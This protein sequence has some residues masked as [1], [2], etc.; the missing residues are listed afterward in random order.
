ML[1]GSIIP[2]QHNI[3]IGT[4]DTSKNI[5]FQLPIVTNTAPK[6]LAPTLQVHPGWNGPSANR[7]PPTALRSGPPMQIYQPQAMLPFHLSLPVRVQSMLA[8]NGPTP[9][10]VA[11]RAPSHP[12]LDELRDNNS[13]NPPDYDLSV[14]NARVCV[15]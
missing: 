4:W 14:S 8:P 6:S 3:D 2:E 13:Y 15:L 9:L 10:L 1:P 12:V 11:L 5:P 7:P